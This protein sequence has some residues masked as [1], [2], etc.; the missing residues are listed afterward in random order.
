M[1]TQRRNFYASS[2]PPIPHQIRDQKSGMLF[3]NPNHIKISAPYGRASL[4]AA[5]GLTNG[6]VPGNIN[7]LGIPFFDWKEANT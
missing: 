4:Y 5:F 1:M 7:P 6:E 3:L 2:Y